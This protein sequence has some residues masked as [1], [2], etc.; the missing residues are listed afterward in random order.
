MKNCPKCAAKKVTAK[1]PAKPPVETIARTVSY[2]RDNIVSR[3]IIRRR[4]G[5]VTVFAFDAGQGLSEHTAPF[6]ALAQS[7]EGTAEVRIDGKPYRLKA[8]QMV[9]LPKD[10]PHALKALTRF[11]MLLTMIKA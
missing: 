11:K 8:G 1:A 5:T 6:E 7:L 4:Y 3:E 9:V 2:Q 10:H